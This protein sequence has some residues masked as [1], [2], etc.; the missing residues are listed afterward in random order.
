MQAQEAGLLALLCELH[1]GRIKRAE[2]QSGL[3][4][5]PFPETHLTLS[6]SNP[7]LPV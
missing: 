5:G 3:P 4:Q 6:C 2:M 1:F 7:V